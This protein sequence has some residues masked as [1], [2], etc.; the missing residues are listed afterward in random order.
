MNQKHIHLKVLFSQMQPEL[1]RRSVMARAALQPPE[2]AWR[3]GSGQVP[4]AGY[5]HAA[6]SVPELDRC[7][8]DELK[9]R[10]WAL[11]EFL[12]EKRHGGVLRLP[13]NYAMDVLQFQSGEPICRQEYLF[14]WRDFALELGQDFFTCAGLAERDLEDHCRTTDFLWPSCIRTDRVDLQHLLE[15]GVAENHYHMNGSTQSF[16]LAWAFLMNHPEAA[17]EYAAQEEFREDVD[18]T[19]SFG[20]QDNRLSWTERIR[21]AAWLRQSLFLALCGLCRPGDMT[22]EFY[23]WAGSRDKAGTVKAAVQ[24]ARLYVIRHLGADQAWKKLDY[25]LWMGGYFSRDFARSSRRFLAGE[26]NLLYQCFRRCYD[27]SF[28]PDV[29]DLLYLYLLYKIRF[30]KELVQT[31]RRPGFRNFSDYQDRK[32][33]LWGQFE[34]YW[35]E[36]CRLSA[37]NTLYVP[38]EPTGAGY[39]K[40]LPPVPVDSREEKE[41]CVTSLEL[42]IMPA[43][44]PAALKQKILQTDRYILCGMNL[45]PSGR[46]LGWKEDLKAYLSGDAPFFYVLHFAKKPLERITQERAAQNIPCLR[47]EKQYRTVERQA[48]A[49]AEALNKSSYLSSRIRGIDACSHEIGCRPE[50]FAV[51]F[52]YLRAFPPGVSYGVDSA[53]YH[54]LLHA[55]YHAGEDFLDLADGLRAIDEAV[56]FLNLDSGERLGH[57]L[58][59]GRSPQEYYR[60]KGRCV[61][62]PAQDLLDNLVWLL[63]RTLEWGVP[64][65][66]ALRSRWKL[67][68]EKLFDAVYGDFPFTA[69]GNAPVGRNLLER[70]YDAWRLRGDDPR[71]YRLA[72]E[73]P[74]RFRSVLERQKRQDYA[75]TPYQRAQVNRMKWE[76]AEELNERDWDA[77]MFRLRGDPLIQQLVYAYFY[78]AQ[79]RYRGQQEQRFF[80]SNEE[81]R[82]LTAVQDRMMELAAARGLSIECNPSSNQLIGAFGEYRNHPVFRFNH[83][84]LPVECFP[85]KDG[86]LCVSINTDDLGI[87]DTSLENEYALVYSALQSFTGPDGKQLI[88]NSTICAYL[89]LLRKMGRD[90]AFPKAKR[91]SQKRQPEDRS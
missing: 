22:R 69:G 4:E 70:Y 81:I 73:E 45:L 27:G 43:D 13:A 31:N 53:R 34:S 25:A 78:D 2:S 9:Q 32:A 75:L 11:Q 17:E 10:C 82:V 3:M 68:A 55:T 66:D 91:S 16:P 6:R 20:V 74:E 39:R 67:L 86:Q 28:P 41:R 71:L 77:A 88:G 51:A 19:Y 15:A 83:A 63:Y 44:T 85:G 54:P 87:F 46:Y 14:S 1:L 80:V 50:V 8:Q 36:S 58:A 65:P 62:L 21:E 60:R 84:L 26:R 42:R 38:P 18:G 76:K 48:K 7:T 79:V 40:R 35:E 56:C 47:H 33:L 64:A 37:A 57:A 24:N 29:C 49:M 5:L 23:R 30:R 59:L 72:W 61:V 52:R 90:M 89:D 12:E